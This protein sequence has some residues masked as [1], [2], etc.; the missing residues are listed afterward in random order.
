MVK[1]W[2][3]A[4]LKYASP[5]FLVIIPVM[6]VYGFISPWDVSEGALSKYE[7]GLAL[8]VGF[9]KETGSYNGRPFDR[10]SRSYIVI[11]NNLHSKS[12]TVYAEFDKFREV[13]E[14]EGGLLVFVLTYL[15]LMLTTWY[16]WVKPHNKSLKEMDR[17]NRAAP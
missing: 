17:A 3:I 11:D 1:A 12:V 10:Q 7:N 13:K 6:I 14:E 16:F 9:N 8:F 2:F 4:V 5:F 15:S